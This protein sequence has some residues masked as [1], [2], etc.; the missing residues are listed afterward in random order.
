LTEREDFIESLR[1]KTGSKF[2]NTIL[3]NENVDLKKTIDGLK[4]E[5]QNLYRDNEKLR[6]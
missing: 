2:G 6:L 5:I 1:N 4:N 3:A